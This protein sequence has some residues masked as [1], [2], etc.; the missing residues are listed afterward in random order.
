ML[1]TV[2]V[3][4]F[5]FLSLLGPRARHRACP[6]FSSSSLSVDMAVARAR[7]VSLSVYSLV[8]TTRLSLFLLSVSFKI[9]VTPNIRWSLQLQLSQRR[10]KTR[11]SAAEVLGRQ[12]A[13]CQCRT[14]CAGAVM[15][16]AKRSENVAGNGLL[17]GE[18]AASRQ[19]PH[20]TQG[21][22]KSFR[23]YMEAN[24]F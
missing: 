14:A 24:C 15:P 17:A 4:P 19:R 9:A 13:P 6:T 1:P 20:T 22:W 3:E 16:A 7:S 10:P 21:D 8:Y 5:I 12:Q 2:V 11:A 23:R 18:T